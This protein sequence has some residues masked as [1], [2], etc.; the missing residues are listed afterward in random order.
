M[1]A[2]TAPIGAILSSPRSVRAAKESWKPP[3]KAPFVMLA[4][5]VIHEDESNSPMTHPI[6][7][8]RP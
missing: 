3:I 1:S 2:K 6:V 7:R 8:T 4:V 5:F